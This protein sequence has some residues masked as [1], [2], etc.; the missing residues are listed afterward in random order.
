MSLIPLAVSHDQRFIGSLLIV[1]EKQDVE[2]TADGR[3]GHDPGSDREAQWHHRPDLPGECGGER[4]GEEPH[5][6]PGAAA[7]G[8]P[9]RGEL[10]AAERAE[11]PRQVQVGDAVEGDRAASPDQVPR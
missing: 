9:V 3:G 1:M 11:V 4:G 5:G 2:P 10:E 7:R 8:G 6:E